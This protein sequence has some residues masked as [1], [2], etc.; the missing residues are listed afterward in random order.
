MSNQYGS[1]LSGGQVQLAKQYRHLL[2]ALDS[3]FPE[4]FKSRSVTA[5]FDDV[6][7][8]D[9]LKLK[10]SGL[11]DNQAAGYDEAKDLVSHAECEAVAPAE[12]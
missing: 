9:L 6:V 11:L 10:K 1:P 3:E 8:G 5:Q 2:E 7:T 12:C 4:P